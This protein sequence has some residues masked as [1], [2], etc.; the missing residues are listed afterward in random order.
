MQD[1]QA[2]FILGALAA[3]NL[4]Q[5]A[6][7][8]NPLGVLIPLAF[9]L[10][11]TAV[12]ARRYFRLWTISYALVFV[13]L[14]L[15]VLGM[16]A[17]HHALLSTLEVVIY[18]ASGWYSVLAGNAIV[19]R[20]IARP[21]AVALNVAPV[22][23]FVVATALGARFDV[24]VVPPLLYY[25]GTQ[26]R[27]GLD[28]IRD[29]A[30]EGSPK[31][32]LG[33]LVI[34]TGAFVLAYPV[35]V[36]AGVAWVGFATSG[37][38]H[39]LCGM[40]MIVYFLRELEGRLREQN[41]ELRELQRVQADFI[42]NMSHEF[43]TPLTAIKTAAWLLSSSGGGN[44]DPHQREIVAMLSTNA[45][46]FAGLVDDVLAATK[47][48]SG[49]LAY[50]YAAVDLRELVARAVQEL[51]HLF[52]DKGVALEMALPE[53]P[54]AAEVDARRLA[55]VLANLLTNAAKFTPAGGRV[56]IALMGPPGRARVAV[57]D[58]GVGVAPGNERRVFLKFF[59]ED[60]SMR[61]AAGGAGL[62]LAISRAIVEEGHGG[63]IGLARNPGRGVTVWFEVPLAR[64]GAAAS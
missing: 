22:A 23:Y 63:A 60:T 10:G 54:L 29:P 1:P 36:Q 5:F 58:D 6:I 11:I 51:E 19:G 43:R 35:L 28:I 27:L 37:L 56:R 52:G 33:G 45:E 3:M 38:L 17:G 16:F 8:L 18:V 46:R 30:N 9:S 59:Q 62:G 64:P 61:R 20:V 24:A 53:A 25:I 40:A 12:H 4:E 7:L 55:Q 41:A 14:V 57:E 49:T 50:A 2:A 44:L 31:R 47:V 13:T 42:G 39:L 48:E 21:L 26:V 32:W 34:A 15:E